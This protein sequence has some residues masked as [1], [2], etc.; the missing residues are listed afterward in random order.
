MPEVDIDELGGEVEV[1]VAVVVP[2]VATLG[3][4]DRKRRDLALHRPRVQDVLGVQL[5]DPL[6][7]ETLFDRHG[8]ILALGWLWDYSEEAEMTEVLEA[9][10]G[11]RAEIRQIGHWIAEGL[12]HRTDA[13]VLSK[14]RKQ[15]LDLCEAF[16]LYAERRARAGPRRETGAA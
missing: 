16:P 9:R 3:A 10:L 5:L 6:R 7:V 1:A 4:R 13:A 11:E 2:E 14:I 12:L 8:T 15:V